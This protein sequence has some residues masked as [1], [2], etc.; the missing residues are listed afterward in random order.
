LLEEL[1]EDDSS[2]SAN[3]SEGDD[4][5][6]KAPERYYSYATLGIFMSVMSFMCVK[7]KRT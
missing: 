4:L 1:L 6:T 3:D 5:G 2:T 7:Y